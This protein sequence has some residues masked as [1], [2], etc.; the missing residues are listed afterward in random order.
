MVSMK[1]VLIDARM[2]NSSGIG[3]YIKNNILGGIYTG[4]IG[5]PA[6]LS[7]YPDLDVI[8]FNSKIYGLKEQFCF[9]FSIRKKYDLVHFPHYNVPFFFKGD[10]I[11]TVH[12]LIHLVY[13]ELLPKLGRIYVK[14]IM[15]HAVRN[16]KKVITVSE[17]SK[18]DIL[19]FF[20]IPANKIEVIYNGVDTSVF[21]KIDSSALIST[22]N[23]FSLSCENKYLLFVG[24]LKPH[25]NL[26][27]LVQAFSLIS[28]EDSSVKL[29]LAGKSFNDLKLIETIASLGLSDKVIITGLIS[30]K[31]IVDLYN[32]ADLV[33]F[34][35]LYEGFGLPPLEAMACETPVVCSNSSSIPE[36]AGDATIYFNPE[37]IEEIVDSIKKVL[38]DEAC[39]KQLIEKGRKRVKIFKW[40]NAT[41]KLKKVIKNI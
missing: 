25:K 39:A 22:R 37:N 35:S 10:Y 16:A 24:N 29:I 23:K 32:I 13:P 34:P 38:Y 41:D 8:S 30:Q 9:P 7:K 11:V 26:N 15:G 14:L 19:R 12:D 1:K 3:E 18:K 6:E 33:V 17:C 31:E 2:I 28:K 5:V 40:T 36:V 27:R 21:H 20:S 4:A